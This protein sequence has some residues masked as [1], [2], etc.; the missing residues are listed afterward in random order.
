M[1]GQLNCEFKF[2]TFSCPQRR[3]HQADMM[4]KD[5]SVLLMDA[6][7]PAVCL[8]K[9]PKS[10]VDVFVTVLENDGSGMVYK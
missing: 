5:Y 8:E 1:K 10:V 6:L 3:P 7:E 9:Y 4:D 2:A